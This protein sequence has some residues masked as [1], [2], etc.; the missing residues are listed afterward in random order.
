MHIHICLDPQLA[1]CCFMVASHWKERMMPTCVAEHM[2]CLQL[3]GAW[4]VHN[5]GLAPLYKQATVLRKQFDSF[6]IDHIF[7]WVHTQLLPAW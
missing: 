3:N 7:R 5:A 6:R 1:R 4:Q 2:W